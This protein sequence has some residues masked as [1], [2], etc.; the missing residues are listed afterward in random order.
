[1]PPRYDR[2]L[3]VF[4]QGSGLWKPDLIRLLLRSVRP[5][6]WPSGG[7]RPARRF[8]WMRAVGDASDA[9][10]LL[11]CVRT[12][13]W[14]RAEGPMS[15]H[16]DCFGAVAAPILAQG[17][18]ACSPASSLGMRD[19]VRRGSSRTGSPHRQRQKGRMPSA[20]RATRQT[21]RVARPARD[22]APV[23]LVVR[24][25]RLRSVDG[26][27]E[28]VLSSWLPGADRNRPS[29]AART[30]CGCLLLGAR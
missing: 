24:R 26:V 25:R 16:S 10:N 28:L 18:A 5:D 27:A 17:C 21:T 14:R 19:R 12:G 6:T 23:R 2:P 3:T 29:S 1:M 4:E 15:A 22:R 13:D 8:G 20:C 7:L 9:F 11:G 30:G